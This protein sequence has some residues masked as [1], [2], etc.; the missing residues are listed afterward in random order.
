[1]KSFQYTAKNQQGEVVS[2]VIETA[3]FGDASEAL[4]RQGLELLSLNERQQI[5]KLTPFVFSAVD[6][7][8]EKVEGTLK[9][10]DEASVRSKLKQ[11]F[12]YQ[13]NSVHAQSIAKP[14]QTVKISARDMTAQEHQQS[15]RDHIARA[16]ASLDHPPQ[17]KSDDQKIIFKRE[18]PV[19]PTLQVISEEELQK[20]E[21]SIEI[22]LQTKSVGLTQGT[23]ERLIHLKTMINLVRENQNKKRW[24]NLKREISS[25]EQIADREVRA[26]EDK[27]WREHEEKD[28]AKK[29]DSYT[30]F[31]TE[32]PRPI[33]DL[34]SRF[35]KW[36]QALQV[37]DLPNEA[38]DQ[39]LLVKQQYE[40]V[41]FELQRFSGALLVFYLLCFFVGYYLKRNGVDDH[42]LTRIYDTTV[43]KEL[44]LVLFSLF[45]LL[46]V[47]VDFLD[48]R[49]KY[50]A[51]VVTL[52]LVTLGFIFW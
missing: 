39:Q 7:L 48:K 19:I 17:Q 43:F 30:Q 5:E 21:N 2:G 38:D 41:W 4:Q 8:G 49:V 35:S 31:S 11:D 32:K 28:P 16:E 34:D 37:L 15:R 47:R 1:M 23:K 42:I 13:V 33:I 40:S 44:V 18:P 24:K 52:F 6:H 22:L 20:A 29:I 50:D 27:R 9:A 25:A 10:A 45:C 26:Y 12:G 46:T 51:M 14:P 36:K 3:G